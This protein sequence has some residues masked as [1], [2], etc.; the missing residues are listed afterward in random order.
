IIFSSSG[1]LDVSVPRVCFPFKRDN[2]P[3][4][5][6]V[7]PFG[8]PRLT[9]YLHLIVAYRSLSRPSSPL[10]AKASTVRPYLLSLLSFLLFYNFFHDVNELVIPSNTS[11]IIS[12]SCGEYRSRTDD[13]LRARQAL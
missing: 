8:N 4:V 12:T 9:G 13:L 3:S 7:A 11:R 1:Y 6:W 10:R 5:C 2:T